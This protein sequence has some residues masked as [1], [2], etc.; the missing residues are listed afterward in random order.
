MTI[1]LTIVGRIVGAFIPSWQTGLMLFEIVLAVLTAIFTNMV[2]RLNGNLRIICFA[3]I[4]VHGILCVWHVFHPE[5]HQPEDNQHPEDDQKNVP[6]YVKISGEIY[7]LI[8]ALA[9]VETSGSVV[10]LGRLRWIGLRLLN[11]VLWLL[12]GARWL[13]MRFSD[14]RAVRV[15]E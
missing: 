14:Y 5:V 9:V 4:F 13:G 11:W 12:D 2:E 6:L 7:Q 8:P 10:I 15:A 3:L 1:G